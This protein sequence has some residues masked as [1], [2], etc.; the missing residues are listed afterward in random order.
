MIRTTNHTL[1]FTNTN[2]YLGL[3]TFLNECKYIA[4][5]YLDYLWIN[6][7]NYTIKNK[8]SFFDIQNNE[9]DIP[10]MLSNV[11]IENNILNI[12][13][14]LSA[15]V[16]K[17]ILTQIL[18][19]IKATTEKQR[20]RIWVFNKLCEEGKYNERLYNKIQKYLPLK[21]S[22]DN[23]N[24]EFNSLCC[25]FQPCESGEFNGF[26]QLASLGKNYEKIRIP[27]K[28][29]RNNKKYKDWKQLTS[30][31]VGKDFVNI[32]WENEV[33]MKE[34]GEVVGADQ[35]KLT[36]VTLSDR[37]ITPKVNNHG[38]SLDSIIDTLS[39][40]RKGSK[41]FKKA[42]KHRE[43]FIHW[44][45]NQLNLNNVKHLKL[46]EVINI[47][48]KNKTSRI[49][50]HWTNTIIRDK[51][52]SRCEEYGVHYTLQS[53]TYRSQRCSECGL[54]RKSNRK[55]KVYICSGCGFSD[56]ADY[57]ASC[58]HEQD[59]PDIP[60]KLRKL[61]L[62]RKGFYWKDTGFYSLAG[63]DLTVHLDPIN[64]INV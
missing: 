12:N 54:V 9:L 27:I 22:I 47:G 53:C 6:K 52:S 15:R 33:S 8:E 3:Q 62:N 16:K 5:L 20:R 18:G 36:V 55:G 26:L 59:L 32:R 23:I 51:I 57:N 35:G 40:K 17:C 31:L 44:S 14:T 21:P 58:N 19:I 7:I 10:S 43:N 45:I 56:D 37:Q 46:E 41:K 49:L 4:Q 30:F 42:Q 2:K 39:R 24:Y 63:D 60:L 64:K 28:Y 48:Y 25:T 13:S 29:H 50:S 1:K 61:N 38:H 11:D 34:E